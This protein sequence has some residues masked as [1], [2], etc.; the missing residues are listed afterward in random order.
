M[1]C[2]NAI[3]LLLS[4]IGDWRLS[5]N[6]LDFA[7][8]PLLTLQ[9]WNMVFVLLSSLEGIKLWFSHEF[10]QSCWYVMKR[11]VIRCFFLFAE[12]HDLGTFQRSLNSTFIVL[13]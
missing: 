11:E 2:A 13:V 5:I 7:S 8:Y 6:W 12:F 1:K 4:E 10:L 3:C 9:L